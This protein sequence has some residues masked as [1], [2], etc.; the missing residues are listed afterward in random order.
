M[1]NALASSLHQFYFF[2]ML[3]KKKCL[4]CYDVI[5]IAS[6]SAEHVISSSASKMK[7]FNS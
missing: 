7:L 5:V 3:Q 2:Y 4:R 6:F 1:Y